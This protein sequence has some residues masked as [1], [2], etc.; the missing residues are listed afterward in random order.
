MLK[1]FSMVKSKLRVSL[2][3]LFN[4]T[5]FAKFGR[6]CFI[7]AP[8]RLDGAGGIEL[9]EKTVMQAGAWL[10]CV[11]IEGKPATL[12]FGK[13]CVLGYNNHITSVRDVKVGDYVL[14]ANNVYIS[15][16]MHAYQD[17][18]RP[19][20]QQPVV[21]KRAVSIGS[22]SWLGE[23]VCVIGANV[24]K[25]CVIGANAVVTH[26]IPDYSVAVGSPAKVIKKYSFEKKEWVPVT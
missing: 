25:N 24:G 12:I 6:G 16:N 26:D 3:K 18:E 10:Y 22:G 14:T 5:G 8:F 7:A 20:L 17:V 1:A 4:A 9:G 11:G 15:D 2:F 23:N 21:F 13:G 19:I